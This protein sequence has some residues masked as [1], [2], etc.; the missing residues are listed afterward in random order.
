MNKGLFFASIIAFASA[1]VLTSCN[2]DFDCN[3]SVDLPDP[4][5]ISLD[6][7]TT[8]TFEKTTEEVATTQCNAY[9]SAS[10]VLIPS[11]VSSAD[12]EITC[13]IQ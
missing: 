1:I 2:K 7:D 5:G 6:F 8:F 13:A 9:E 11:G 4:V 3:C 10:S 12:A